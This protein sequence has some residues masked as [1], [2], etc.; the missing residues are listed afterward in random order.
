MRPNVLG[1]GAIIIFCKM[2][3]IF[4]I[5]VY[6]QVAR[7]IPVGKQNQHMQSVICSVRPLNQSCAILESFKCGELLNLLLIKILY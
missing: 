5:F 7:W 6:C 1:R 3:R 2:V 4:R